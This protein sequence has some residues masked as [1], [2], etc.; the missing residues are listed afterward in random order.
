MSN[1]TLNRVI[2]AMVAKAEQDGFELPHFCVHYLRRTGST[3]LQEAVFNPDWIETCLAHE[4]KGVRA[5]YNKAE[6][7]EQR[8]EMLQCWA[9]MVDDWIE[10]AKMTANGQFRAD[11]IFP[12]STAHPLISQN[13][14]YSEL[15][16]RVS[17][18]KKAVSQEFEPHHRGV[19]TSFVA[20]AGTLDRLPRA[21]G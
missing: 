8:R 2:T 18:R 16:A 3:L 4:Q 17:V 6:Y 19:G 12:D 9:D 7:A 21:T 1:V 11:L 14:D 5:I 20:H 15:A 10:G 13:T